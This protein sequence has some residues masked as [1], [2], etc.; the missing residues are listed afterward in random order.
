MKHLIGGRQLALVVHVRRW[1]RVGEHHIVQHV[2]VGQACHARIHH[3]TNAATNAA[4]SS[5]SVCVRACRAAVATAV[6]QTARQMRRAHLGAVHV[7]HVAVHRHATA[8]F[9]IHRYHVVVVRIHVG[10]QFNRVE[11]LVHKIVVVA[12]ERVH[13]LR[14]DGQRTG[15]ALW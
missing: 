7:D 4:S 11:L 9:S 2:S 3:R 12:A 8:T 6:A 1:R 13:V 10:F 5:S 15:R 14:A